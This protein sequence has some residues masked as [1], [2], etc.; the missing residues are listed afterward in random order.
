MR[1]Q[2]WTNWAV[3]LSADF[4]VTI[5]SEEPSD[6]AFIDS[7]TKSAEGKQDAFVAFL[8]NSFHTGEKEREGGKKTEQN[9]TKQKCAGCLFV[10]LI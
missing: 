1:D 5:T 8:Q 3:H 10:K 7:L 4:L 9:R 2:R 6:T